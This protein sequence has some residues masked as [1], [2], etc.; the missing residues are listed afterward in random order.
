MTKKEDEKNLKENLKEKEKQQPLKAEPSDKPQKPEKEDEKVVTLSQ[1]DYDGIKLQMAKVINDYKDLQRD[2]ENYRKRS[3]EEID[4]AKDLGIEK[5]LQV[6]FPALD[7]FKKA[8]EMIGDK[9]TLSGVEMIEK[10]LFDALKKFDVE[11][12][13]TKNKKF[14]PMCHN[15]VLSIEDKNVENGYIVD[16]VESGYT[17]H[18]KVIKFAQVVVCNR[19]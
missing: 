1:E 15:A 16:E 6:I 11:K 12:I 19:K 4:S 3:R 10:S 8:K 14:D 7:S 18:G 2:L 17:R 9:K 5:A 13:E